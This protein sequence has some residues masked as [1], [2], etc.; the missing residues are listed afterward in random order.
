MMKRDLKQFK[1]VAGEKVENHIY[2][3]KFNQNQ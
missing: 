3:N 1:M 2:Q